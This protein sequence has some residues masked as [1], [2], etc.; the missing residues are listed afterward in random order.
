MRTAAS[1]TPGETGEYDPRV[2][3]PEDSA[4]R[5]AAAGAAL[6]LGPVTTLT[7]ARSDDA[8][9]V[10]TEMMNFGS[11]RDFVTCLFVFIFAFRVVSVSRNRT[12][13]YVSLL[14]VRMPSY[15]R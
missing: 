15:V 3:D 8:M 9:T 13:H 7:T 2:L 14:Y 1:R 11:F 4:S 6:D 10:T 5:R 12:S